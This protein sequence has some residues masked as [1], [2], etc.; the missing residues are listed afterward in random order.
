HIKPSPRCDNLRI[1]W[2]N[3]MDIKNPEAGG[4]EVYTHE[5]AKRLVKKGHPV[6][7]FTRNFKDAKPRDNIDG[8]E[9]IRAGGKYSVYRQAK[10]HYKREFRGKIDLVI[11]EIN[12]KP[13]MTPK[14]VEEK[15]I[16]MIHQLAREYWFH[17]TPFP[18]SYIGYHFLEDRWLRSYIDVPVVTVSDSTKRDLEDF[19][20]KK[21]FLVHN[22]LN[23]MPV[24]KVPEKSERPS[25]V[26]MGRMKRAKKP[27]DVVEAFRTV[28][29]KFRN[30][31]LLM[32][33]DGYLRR[34]LE[35]GAGSGVRFF[36]YLD[37][38]TRDELVRRAWVI[39]VPGMREGWGQVVTDANALGTPVVGYKVPGLR[40]S[41]KNGFNGL[42]VE[43]SSE[44]LADGIMRI[45]SEND[46]RENLS[47]NA[48]EWARKFNW[49]KTAHEFL[50]I[51][52]KVSFE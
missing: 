23:V 28:R 35:S 10:K 26:F 15:I 8:I 25:I 21:I 24:V 13:F 7:L 20:F 27:G 46:L 9:I 11:D 4:A 49:D 45:L 18:M 2:Y 50:N 31:E 29:E 30:A 39:A 33:G 42:L 17:E 1:L 47:R 14:F 34:R 32:I 16:A 5:I 43:S 48:I 22:G 37:S 52:E 44:A 12:T 36:G 19:G 38:E 6:T 41:I 40:D 51:V 3:W